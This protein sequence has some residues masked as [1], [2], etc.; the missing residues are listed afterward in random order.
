MIG[1]TGYEFARRDVYIEFER[2]QA[3]IIKLLNY[4]ITTVQQFSEGTKV[5]L[6]NSRPHQR[7]LDVAATGC[8]KYMRNNLTDTVREII[9]R[10]YPITNFRT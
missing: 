8:A 10:K 2:C 3:D 7:T 4:A 9:V 6:Q 5:Q 1:V